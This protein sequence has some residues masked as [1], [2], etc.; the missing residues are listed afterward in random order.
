MSLSIR[1]KE[2]RLRA[3]L[4][5]KQLADKAGVSQ[6]VISGIESGKIE[7]S[8]KMLKFARALN[9]RAEWL[10]SHKFS[11]DVPYENDSSSG[12]QIKVPV[13]DF[14]Q[15]SA[16]LSGEFYPKE[17]EVFP[18]QLNQYLKDDSFSSVMPDDSMHNMHSNDSIVQGEMLTFNQLDPSDAVTVGNTYLIDVNGSRKVRL[19]A[20]DGDV[21]IFKAFNDKYAMFRFEECKPVAEVIFKYKMIK[22]V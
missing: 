17:Y 5:Q 6:A 10:I 15:I 3:G 8:S 19:L 9:V 16:F 12:S 11:I 21:K 2:A 1:F 20:F 22:K 18:M 7:E 13:V 14:N 4:T